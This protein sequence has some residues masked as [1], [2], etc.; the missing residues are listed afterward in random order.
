MH[1][2]LLDTSASLIEV[3]QR[4]ETMNAAGEKE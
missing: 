2:I 1:L 3:S 4:F